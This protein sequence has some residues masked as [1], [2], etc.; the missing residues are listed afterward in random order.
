M[1]A[2]GCDHGGYDLKQALIKH[3]EDRNIEYKDFGCYSKERVDYPEYALKVCEAVTSKKYD[4]GVLCCGTGIGMSIFANKVKG[5]RAA[6]VENVFSARYTKM[7]NDSNVICMGGRVTGDGLAAMLFDEWYNA[8]FQGGR[9][10]DR[11]DMISDYENRT[12]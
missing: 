10:K 5:I 11:I 9:H 1:I 8:K 7:H 2:I 4:S 6:L 12:K 3:F